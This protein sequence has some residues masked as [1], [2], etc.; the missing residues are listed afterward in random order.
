MAN[1]EM[2]SLSVTLLVTLRKFLSL[3]VSIVY[4]GNIFT[5]Q[6]WLGTALVFGGTLV[7]GGVDEKLLKLLRPTKPHR[8]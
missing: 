6:H 8:E 3:L 5:A 1:S 7:Y 2:E 4:F